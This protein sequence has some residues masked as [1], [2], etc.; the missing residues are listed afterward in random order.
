MRHAVAVVVKASA[1][2]SYRELK[3]ADLASSDTGARQR[4]GYF[5]SVEYGVKSIDNF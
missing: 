3:R 5:L 2:A 1:D 4:F